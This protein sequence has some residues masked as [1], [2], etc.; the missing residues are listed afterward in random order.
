MLLVVTIAS[1]MADEEGSSCDDREGSPAVTPIASGRKK[2]NRTLTAK[3]K[4]SSLMRKEEQL[5]SDMKDSK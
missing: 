5:N 2:R 1:Y 3:F 4:D